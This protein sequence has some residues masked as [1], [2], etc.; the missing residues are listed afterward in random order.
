MHETVDRERPTSMHDNSVFAVEV[1]AVFTC[2]PFAHPLLTSIPI[3]CSHLSIPHLCSHMINN[4]LEE[5]KKQ[6]KE[7]REQ[8]EMLRITGRGDEAAHASLNWMYSG[9]QKSAAEQEEE[10]ESFLLGKKF[11]ANG[12][13]TE[14]A[15]MEEA[16]DAGA[17]VAKEKNMV[18]TL[19]MGK[20]TSEAYEEF[21]R[22]L[23]DPLTLMRKREEMMRAKM[24][25]DVRVKEVLQQP[26]RERNASK[27]EKKEKKVSA[28]HM[29]E[30]RGA[31]V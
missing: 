12:G 15:E 7:E 19:F 1:F 30:R 25:Q 26:E 11:E 23:E 21:S 17:A 2:F 9:G 13:K 31:R 4:Q 10:A 3:R 16:R 8:E 18:G 20:A 5:Y 28:T 14:V 29:C 27:K 24:G 6:I 22:N